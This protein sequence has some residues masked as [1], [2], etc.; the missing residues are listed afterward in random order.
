MGLTVVLE[1]TATERIL[2]DTDTDNAFAGVES[3][4]VQ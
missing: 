4:L 3:S 2:Y 1:L